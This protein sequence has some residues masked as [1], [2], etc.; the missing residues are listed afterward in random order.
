MDEDTIFDFGQF[1]DSYEDRYDPDADVDD[2]PD[3]DD[4]R[5]E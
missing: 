1:I 5:E 2:H 4:Y 3:D